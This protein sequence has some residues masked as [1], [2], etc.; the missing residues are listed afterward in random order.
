V[1]K[2]PALRCQVAECILMPGWTLWRKVSYLARNRKPDVDPP[3]SYLCYNVKLD[4]IIIIIVIIITKR[5]CDL[6][7]VSVIV[8]SLTPSEWWST[9]LYLYPPLQPSSAVQVYW[10]YKVTEQ[11]LCLFVHGI[12]KLSVY[13]SSWNIKSSSGNLFSKACNFLHG[14][15]SVLP[16]NGARNIL[17]IFFLWNLNMLPLLIIYFQTLVTFTWHFFLDFNKAQ[18]QNYAAWPIPWRWYMK[19]LGKICT[20]LPGCMMSQHRQC[21]IE[22]CWA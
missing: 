7:N 16:V 8:H 11:Q 20:H 19:F 10:S 4:K 12:P 1:K 6:Q 15:F 2:P 9:R 5:Y 18:D 22:L 14:I 13:F 17:I 21:I 3:A